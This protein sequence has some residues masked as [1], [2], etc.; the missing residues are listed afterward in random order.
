MDLLARGLTRSSSF[1]FS[2]L[3]LYTTYRD[4][5]LWTIYWTTDRIT[6]SSLTCG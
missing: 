4:F 1:C 2:L 5:L 3:S 6:G